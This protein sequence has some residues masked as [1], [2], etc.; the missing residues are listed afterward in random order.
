VAWTED[1]L[2]EGSRDLFGQGLSSTGHDPRALQAALSV[3][4][5]IDTRWS[6][7][8]I[9]TP[10][11]GFRLAGA[12]PDWLGMRAIVRTALAGGPT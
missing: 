11:A 3:V 10:L 12:A 8:E 9:H 2:A 4:V 5:E 7:A 6:R 1:S